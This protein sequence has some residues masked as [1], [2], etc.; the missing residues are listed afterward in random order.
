MRVRRRSSADHLVFQR[1]P[2]AHHNRPSA[3]SPLSS[4]PPTSEEEV[5]AH[6]PTSA[7]FVVSPTSS[8]SSSPIE[9]PALARTQSQPPPLDTPPLSLKLF[10]TD[11]Q[12][13]RIL[14]HS[15]TASLGEIPTPPRSSSRRSTPTPPGAETPT[16]KTHRSHHSS[17]SLSSIFGRGSHPD[18]PVHD[19]VRSE[20]PQPRGREKNGTK[21]HSFFSHHALGKVSEAFG[22]EEE[23]KEVGD[24]W[25][26]FRKGLWLIS[27]VCDYLFDM[28]GQAH[29]RSRCLSRLRH[30]CQRPWSATG[31]P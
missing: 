21:R 6:T 24:G 23:H 14:E 9:T 7:H 31:V 2:V 16:G 5:T 8:S 15:R 4:F 25:Q 26:E 18:S 22:L 17:L 29:I 11:T 28:Q 19:E 3:P 10:V 13:H 30:I 27:G 1:D 12:P 20:S